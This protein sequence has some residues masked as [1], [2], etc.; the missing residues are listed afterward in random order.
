MKVKI[1]DIRPLNS[2]LEVRLQFLDDSLT[3]LGE[4]AYTTGLVSGISLAAGKAWL[5]ARI[6]D[7]KAEQDTTSRYSAFKGQ[8]F[9]ETQL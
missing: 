8:T 5:K 4:R 9:D 6:A 3:V 2:S 1:L 7:F